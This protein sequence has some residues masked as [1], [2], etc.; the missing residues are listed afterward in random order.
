MKKLGIL[1]WDEVRFG[2]PSHEMNKNF[3]YAIEEAGGLPI[4]IPSVM[5]PEEMD[6]Y[7]DYVDGVILTGG[8]DIAPFYYG[9]D[10]IKETGILNL[11]RDQSEYEFIKK[12]FQRKTPTLAVCRG[13]QLANVVLGGSLY[14]DI[15]SQV[16]AS[17]VHVV[18]Q[19]PQ[20]PFRTQYHRIDVEED[21][22]LYECLGP[23]HVVNTYHHQAIKDLAEGLKIS[24]VSKDGIIEAIETKDED[25]FFIGI[26]FHPEFTDH[27]HGFKRI[28]QYFIGGIE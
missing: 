10:P 12:I 18:D 27:S 13:M 2:L 20:G 17:L 8:S 4:G 19:D 24:A 7:L 26:Q 3:L 23:D 15:E 28:F 9:E 22:H 5:R 21:S 14:Q 16:P 6:Q 11:D 25:H 1:F